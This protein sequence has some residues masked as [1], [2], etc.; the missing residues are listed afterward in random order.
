[1]VIKSE[2]VT[3]I[4]SRLH[5]D[6][7]IHLL[8]MV[9]TPYVAVMDAGVTSY[10]VVEVC[11]CEFHLKVTSIARNSLSRPVCIARR[12]HRNLK[13]FVIP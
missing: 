8:L 2:M 7:E 5:L 6:V 1:M 4:T 11:L 9:R 10:L 12:Y 13:L 3:D